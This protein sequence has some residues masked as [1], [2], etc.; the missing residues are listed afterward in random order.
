MLR[1]SLGTIGT[2]IMDEVDQCLD[3]IETA[4]GGCIAMLEH[5]SDGTAPE[6]VLAVGLG[7][8]SVDFNT[9]L[10]WLMSQVP[11]E[12]VNVTTG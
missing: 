5:V 7:S 11:V 3:E 4:A 8:A 6:S 9:W 10:E 12:V 2:F 1:A